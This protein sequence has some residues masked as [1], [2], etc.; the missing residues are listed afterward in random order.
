MNVYLRHHL[1]MSYRG[2]KHG[3]GA[4]RISFAKVDGP[5]LTWNLGK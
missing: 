5:S 4:L 1:G 2:K 3:P